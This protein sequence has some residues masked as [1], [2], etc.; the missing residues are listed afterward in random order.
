[1]AY[2]NL[3]NCFSKQISILI[4]VIVDYADKK[5]PEIDNEKL[6]NTA[7]GPGRKKRSRFSTGPSISR[8]VAMFW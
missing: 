6:I 8:S 3:K 5:L 7:I 1:M 4:T 2:I